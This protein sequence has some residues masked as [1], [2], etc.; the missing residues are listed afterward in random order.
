MIIIDTN[1]E[2]V[3]FGC[4]N[5]TIFITSDYTLHLSKLCLISQHHIL[6][7]PNTKLITPWNT[8]AVLDG[9][10]RALAW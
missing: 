4:S 2:K 6:F 1:T 7:L 3:I 5:L 10:Y 9:S 8:D